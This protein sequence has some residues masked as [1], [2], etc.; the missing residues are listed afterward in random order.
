MSELINQY[1]KFF[2]NISF[3]KNIILINFYKCIKLFKLENKKVKL[4][5]YIS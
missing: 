4:K 1:L 3:Y 5:A 2:L